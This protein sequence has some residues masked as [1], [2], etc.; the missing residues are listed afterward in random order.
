M[1]GGSNRKS[2]QL[3]VL[4][5]SYRADRHDGKGQPK[6]RPVAPAAPPSWLD[7][8]AKAEWRRV[9]PEL[10]KLGLLTALDR[11]AFAIYCTCWS[12]FRCYSEIVEREGAV[13]EGHRGV[14]RKH[15][16]LPALHQAADAVRVWAQEFA[17]TPLSR[18]R[19]N[20]PT[21]PLSDDFQKWLD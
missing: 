20:L 17:M 15:P 1:R 9:G 19:I 3:H 13:I 10:E 4:S 16:L 7:K 5:G 6:P 21:E 8:E 12:D 18:S 14:L 11:A 2:K